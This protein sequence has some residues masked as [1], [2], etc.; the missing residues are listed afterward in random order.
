MAGLLIEGA[1]APVA[2]V[3]LAD[4]AVENLSTPLD[5]RTISKKLACYELAIT[6]AGGTQSLERVIKD[7]HLS[8]K[9]SIERKLLSPPIRR[10]EVDQIVELLLGD[11]RCVFA[12]GAGGAGKSAVLHGVV[13]QVKSAGWAVLALRLDRQE[14]FSSTYELGQRFGLVASPVSGLARVA[15]EQPCLLVIDQLDAVSKASGRM[16]Q[17]FDAV[18]D[19]FREAVAFPKMRVLLACRRFDLDNDDRIRSLVQDRQAKQCDIGNLSDEQ[20]AAAIG[21]MG[22]IPEQ[23]T[24]IPTGRSN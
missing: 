1:P 17:S 23:L 20:V 10:P 12:I 2:A 21:A 3:T 16:P 7:Q 13:E 11:G 9:T 18:A 8:W 24:L 15:A 22:I 19:L 14:P 5:K 6:P 4:L